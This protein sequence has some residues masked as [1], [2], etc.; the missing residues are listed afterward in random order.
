MNCLEAQALLSASHD[1]EMIDAA[2]LKAA[3]AHCKQCPECSAFADGLR[4]LDA[5]PVATAPEG[6]V[7]RVME[8]VAPLAAV[9]DEIRNIEADREQVDGLGIELPAPDGEPGTDD[10]P[11]VVTA[12]VAPATPSP[13]GGLTWFVGPVRWATFGAAAALAASALIAFI[14]IGGSNAAPSGTETAATGGSAPIDLTYGAAANKDAGTPAAAAPTVVNPAPAQAP[15]YVL[16]KGFVYQPG[17]LLADSSTATPTIG[18]LSTA[19]ASAGA[20]SA[21]TVFRSP[22]TDGSIVVAS[23][24]GMRLFTPVIRMV[25][26][27]RYQLTSGKSIDRFGTW[28]ALPDRFVTPTDANGTPSFV[29]S[30]TDASGATLFAAVGHTTSDGFAVAPGTSTS[31]PAGGNPSWTWWLPAPANP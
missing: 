22:L 6:L 18:T 17:S 29:R 4:Y 9:R 5:L 3:K 14:V 19:F 10:G 31:D 21:V 11:P 25:S 23:P 30:G 28:P 13:L 27:V 1:G 26:S 16:Y 15:D 20:P 2:E 12:P 24:D 7:E 8:A